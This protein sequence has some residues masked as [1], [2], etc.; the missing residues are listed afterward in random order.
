MCAIV[1]CR[2]PP[3]FG[4]TFSLPSPNHRLKFTG[5]GKQS[6]RL[7]T[8]KRKNA[9]DLRVSMFVKIEFEASLLRNVV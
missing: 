7:T 6:A 4:Q 2:S 5:V 3:H 8:V 1:C 9:S